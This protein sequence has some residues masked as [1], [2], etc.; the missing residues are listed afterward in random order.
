[1]RIPC[2]SST[3]GIRQHCEENSIWLL[4]E[5]N[6]LPQLNHENFARQHSEE[7]SIGLL[8]E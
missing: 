8:D 3:T 4:N 7:R 2:G 6:S 5:E 1:M